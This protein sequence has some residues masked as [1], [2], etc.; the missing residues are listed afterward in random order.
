MTKGKTSLLSPPFSSTKTS[1]AVEGA[2]AAT[3]D[4][5]LEEV[6][7]EVEEIFVELEVVDEG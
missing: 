5:V 6:F 7:V 4:D 3:V 2:A 1:E